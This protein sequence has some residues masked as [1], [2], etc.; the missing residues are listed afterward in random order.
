M[1]QSRVFC[2]LIVFLL[3]AS[4]A[5]SDP[6]SDQAMLFLKPSEFAN[7]TISPNGRFIAF[8]RQL[9]P[10]TWQTRK[11]RAPADYLLRIFIMDLETG[12]VVLAGPR[13]EGKETDLDDWARSARWAADG[14]FLLMTWQEIMSVDPQT[15]EPIER[16][17]LHARL[18]EESHLPIPTSLDDPFIFYGVNWSKGASVTLYSYHAREA[19]MKRFS[20]P[21]LVKDLVVSVQR[22]IDHPSLSL[23]SAMKGSDQGFTWELNTAGEMEVTPFSLGTEWVILPQIEGALRPSEKLVQRYIEDGAYVSEIRLFDYKRNEFVGSSL[24]VER[25]DLENA[26][27]S[28]TKSSIEKM[29]A[30]SGEQSFRAVAD[31][32][33]LWLIDQLRSAYPLASV[34]IMNSDRE[35]KKFALSV[36][37]QNRPRALFIFDAPTR[38][39]R[40]LMESKPELASM[41]L[42][43]GRYIAYESPFE[44]EGKGLSSYLPAVRKGSNKSSQIMVSIIDEPLNDYDWGF[45]SASRFFSAQGYDSLQIMLP[46]SLQ[47]E[48][49]RSSNPDEFKKAIEN[50]RQFITTNIEALLAQADLKKNKSTLHY[51]LVGNCASILP[52]LPDLKPIKS[53]SIIV[54]NPR[55]HADLG[56]A[57]LARI[58]TINRFPIKQ[59][60][61][62]STWLRKMNP[63]KPEIDAPVTI[64]WRED[65]EYWLNTF[66]G[67]E[68]QINSFERYCK[69]KGI[70]FK[71]DIWPQGYWRNPEA[72]KM[73]AAETV[74]IWENVSGIDSKLLDSWSQ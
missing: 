43:E 37:A 11:S 48:V 4:A 59:S 47:L 27:S 58:Q 24:L 62:P 21:G 52:S 34:R 28:L 60:I 71:K 72:W 32:Q 26:Q 15:G 6:E 67:T 3:G 30:S 40:K 12:Q 5:K 22:P 18:R 50:C 17:N 42:S 54:A 64:V 49:A 46:W 69:D 65:N 16:F 10:S 25:R 57:S 61:E 63:E 20:Q 13:D 33:V 38:K 19:R 23:R 31:E 45:S 9:L 56:D 66:F 68:S 7:C 2:L 51:V 53:E 35:G 8:E 73:Y 55:F 1:I 41:E 36:S 39:I 44:R 70:E 74:A 14:T 29:R